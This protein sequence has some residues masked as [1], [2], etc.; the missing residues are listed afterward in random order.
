M[1]ARLTTALGEL[2]PH[3]GRLE[4]RG[5]ATAVLELGRR[6]IVDMDQLRKAASG[7]PV[8]GMLT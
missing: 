2:K 7:T 8:A 3:D 5:A 6:G 4:L 1:P